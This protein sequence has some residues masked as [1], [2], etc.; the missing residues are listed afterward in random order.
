M[1]VPSA[2][3]R[4]R[5]DFFQRTR[6]RPWIA[7]LV[8]LLVAGVIGLAWFLV[9]S[10]KHGGGGPGAFGRRGGR[11]PT[12]VGMATASLADVPVTLDSLGTVT[13]AATVTVRPQVSGVIVK[14]LFKEGQ[15]V[16]RGQPLAIIDQRPLQMQVMQAQGQMTRDEAQLTNARLT[17]QRY[18]TLLA[19]DSIARQDVD[20]QAATV[21]QLEGVVVS[22]RASLG[23]ARLNL[24]YSRV[25]APVSG[26]VGLRAVDVGNY[27][28]AGDANGLVVLTEVDPIDVEFTVPQDQAPQVMQKAAKGTLPVAAM[29]RT[30]TTS[31]A[32]GT[33][34]TLD[35]QVDPSTGTVRAKARFPNG[36]GALF[37]NQFV[38]VRVTLDT[39][40][41]AVVV[42]LTAVRTGPDG[43]F[44]WVVTAQ[45]TAMMRKVTRGETTAT[46]VVVLSGLQAGEKVVTEG[47]D[48][49]TQGGKV[50]LPGQRPPGG[51]RGGKGGRRR[52]GGAGGFAGG[53]GAGQYGGGAGGPAGQAGEGG[54]GSGGRR[55][56]GAGPNGAPGGAGGEGAQT[57]GPGPGAAA[58]GSPAG[59]G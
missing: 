32:Q 36:N 1:D 8:V 40:H 7:I 19:Q 34:S 22:D 55:G 41:N 11:P 49:L 30:R 35:N 57:G 15:L 53:D 37:P 45:R 20:T 33:F 59:A 16:R 28:G 23:T 54:G 51:W 24:G 3:P 25:I 52:G 2:H 58:G 21:K 4:R 46:Q 56:Q 17:L 26:R 13:P 10:A 14:V 18:Q 44:V 6:R 31:L 47:G 27:I 43:D 12:T 5:V 39:L 42:P 48:R 29:D 9:S 38:N 50:M